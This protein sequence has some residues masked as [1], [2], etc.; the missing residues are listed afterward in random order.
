MCI[1][2]Q[3]AVQTERRMSATIN[4]DMWLQ[5][6]WTATKWCCAAS[7]WKIYCSEKDSFGLRQLSTSQFN[8]CY[9]TYSCRRPTHFR[10]IDRIE[11]S[12]FTIKIAS[13]SNVGG[14]FQRFRYLWRG[15][16]AFRTRRPFTNLSHCHT[17]LPI[18]KCGNSTLP[19]HPIPNYCTCRQFQTLNQLQ[20]V[21]WK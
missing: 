10:T 6:A 20:T 12:A 18:L 15:A 8:G 3:H 17:Y 7:R 16:R 13:A 4:M 14:K 1:G 9:N 2:N 19:M 21:E 5:F 11:R